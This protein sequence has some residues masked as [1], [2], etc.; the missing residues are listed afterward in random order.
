MLPATPDTMES[1]RRSSAEQVSWT[2]LAFATAIFQYFTFPQTWLSDKWTTEIPYDFQFAAQALVTG[3]NLLLV[4]V[5]AFLWMFF[6]IKALNS[7]GD[8][9]RKGTKKPE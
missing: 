5:F 8:A 9:P 4:G 3:V 1:R 7:S 6:I 2:L